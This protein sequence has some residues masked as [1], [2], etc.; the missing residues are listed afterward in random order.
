MEY[1]GDLHYISMIVRY[2]NTEKMMDIIFRTNWR[3]VLKVSIRFHHLKNKCIFDKKMTVIKV[4]FFRYE[5]LSLVYK[6]LR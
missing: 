6:N 5:Q 3:F 1:F 4:T 2:N